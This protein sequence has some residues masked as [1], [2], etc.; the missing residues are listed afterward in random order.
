MEVEGTNVGGSG[1]CISIKVDLS[2]LRE[3][4]ENVE[5]ALEE[6]T[7]YS[8]DFLTKTVDEM[9]N[10]KSDY[11]DEIRKTMK[12]MTDTEAPKFIEK[13]QEYCSK[14]ERMITEYQTMEQEMSNQ[15]GTEG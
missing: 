6:F 3:S 4:L 5:N 2:E 14:L 13:I 8:D 1:E 9:E 7:P 12:N 11:I 10:M 15:L